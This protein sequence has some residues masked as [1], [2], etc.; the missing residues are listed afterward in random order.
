MIN[1]H[2]D[3]AGIEL[4]TPGIAVRHASVARHVTDC[5]TRPGQSVSKYMNYLYLLKCRHYKPCKPILSILTSNDIVSTKINDKRDDFDF[6]IVNF[7]FLEGDVPRSTSYGVYISQIFVN[8][9]NKLLT[10]KP[11]NQGYRFHKLPKPFLNLIDDTMIW[12]LNSKLYLNLFCAMDFRN[13]N[14]MVTWCINW[15]RLVALI[16]FSAVH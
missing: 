15:R 14:S 4:A 10:Q 16:I 11:L 1:L 12:Y 13:L 3:R 5:A 7:Q 8:T 9:R 2:R 6:K